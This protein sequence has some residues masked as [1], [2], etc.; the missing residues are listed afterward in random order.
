[1]NSSKDESESFEVIQTGKKGYLPC[2][3]T[4]EPGSKSGTAMKLRPIITAIVENI[5]AGDRVVKMF[6]NRASSD[7]LV[8]NHVNI[9]TV[10]VGV[11]PEHIA[12]LNMLCDMVKKGGNSITQGMIEE[13]QASVGFGIDKDKI[14]DHAQSECTPD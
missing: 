13:A 9:A 1:M 7:D 5:A 4:N 12:A 14:P 2:F 8:G 10:T 3:V 6:S 11:E